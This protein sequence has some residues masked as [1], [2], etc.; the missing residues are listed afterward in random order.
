[1]GICQLGIIFDKSARHYQM[2]CDDL[3]EILGQAAQLGPDRR[4]QRT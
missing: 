1:M 4:I 2:R 3:G